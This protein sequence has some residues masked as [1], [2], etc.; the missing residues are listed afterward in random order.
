[1]KV[2]NN[3][4]F[5]TI[6]GD[7]ECSAAD[8]LSLHHVA[9]EECHQTSV[10][11]VLI[12]PGHNAWSWSEDIRAEIGPGVE[13]EHDHADD[14]HLEHA[15][16]LRHHDPASPGIVVVSSD[17]EVRILVSKLLLEDSCQL[18]VHSVVTSGITI[19]EVDGVAS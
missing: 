11:L 19:L 6:N 18:L 3:I 12:C 8:E 16:D 14:D 9:E 15:D 1:M 13:A 4:T 2:P 17:G 5:F 10:D 7:L